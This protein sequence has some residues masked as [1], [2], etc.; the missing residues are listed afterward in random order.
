[1][2]RNNQNSAKGNAIF[3]DTNVL[4]NDPYAVKV[5]MGVDG[6]KID[7]LKLQDLNMVCIPFTV[8]LELDSVKNKKELISS[9]IVLAQKNIDELMEHPKLSSKL[10]IIHE[11]DW[12]GLD[13]LSRE[14]N[15]FKILASLNYFTK[16]HRDDFKSFKFVSED[17]G[18]RLVARDYFPDVIIETYKKDEVRQTVDIN[19]KTIVVAESEIVAYNIHQLYEDYCQTWLEHNQDSCLQPIE[20]EDY[21]RPYNG[22]RFPWLSKYGEVVQNEGVIVSSVVKEYVNNQLETK[23]VEY[24]FVAMRKGDYFY[25]IDDKI[26]A[27]GIKPYNINGNGYNWPQA[28]ALAALLDPEIDVVIMNSGAGTGKTILALAAALQQ[29]HIYKRIVLAS[30]MVAVDDREIGFIP[31]NVGKKVGFW[32]GPYDNNLDRI[33]ELASR[34]ATAAGLAPKPT[35]GG[36]R[37][38]K[39]ED[40]RTKGQEVHK[41]KKRRED[42]TKNGGLPDSPREFIDELRNTNNLVNVPITNWRGVTWHN[43]MVI[44]DDVQNASNSQFKTMLTRLGENA[45]MV[46]TGD[47]KQI[48]LRRYLNER[49]SGL[50]HAV[51]RLRGGKQVAVINFKD[52]V[53]SPF[54]AFVE[55]VW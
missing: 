36:R 4:I 16:V 1:M 23:E 39:N 38:R 55:E 27:F 29:A 5:L 52:T 2:K 12:R 25:V 47:V 6:K 48:D 10:A 33:I 44:V 9:Q 41:T 24:N 31:G 28:I 11:Q 13:D 54:V 19:V 14:I 51:N 22:H 8:L 20:K 26:A 21:L 17:S 15:D 53:R 45:K 43:A 34:T 37:G 18:C 32:T 7:D 42:S 30:L 40:E 46:L 49:N 50:T 35:K 3:I